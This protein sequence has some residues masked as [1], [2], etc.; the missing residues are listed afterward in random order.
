MAFPRELRQAI[1]D[2]H[3]GRALELDSIN[4]QSCNT[5][6][7]GPLVRLKLLVKETG[8][9]SGQFVVRM[10]LQP[11]L[12][13][14]AANYEEVQRRLQSRVLE[15]RSKG[16]ESA[17]HARIPSALAELQAGWETFLN[18]A[19]EANVINAT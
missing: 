18:F 19:Q 17:V 4:G 13:W 3:T 10:D 15:I 7:F 12:R 9:L 8:K 11:F 14:I 16:C 6:L 1:P 5:L 2:L